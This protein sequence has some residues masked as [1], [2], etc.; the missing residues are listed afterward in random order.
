[1]KSKLF[2]LPLALLFVAVGC[3]DREAQ[4]NAKIQADLLSDTTI[5]VTTTKPLRQDVVQTLSVS[6]SLDTLD[7]VQVGAKV[8]GRLTLVSVKEGSR[9]RAG[10]LIAQVETTDLLLQVQQAQAA[11]QQALSRRAEAQIQVQMTPEQ[12]EAAVKQ[13]EAQLSAAKAQLELV[14]KGARSQ[15]KEQARQRVNQARAALDKARADL[16]RMRKLYEQEAISKADLDAVQAAHDQALAAYQQAVEAYDLIVEGARP[17]EIQQAE[18]AVR[19]AEEA[20]R[21]ARS[22]RSLTQ[23]R[24]QQLE[25]AEAAVTQA[26]AALRLAQAALADAAIYAPFD[27]YVSG[28]PAQV[29]QVVAPG[30]PVA[31]IVSLNGLYFDAQVS[32]TDV[33]QVRPGQPVT[34]RVDA[35]PSREFRGSVIAINPV[36]AELGRMFSVRVGLSDPEKVLRPGMFATGEIQLEVIP[37]SLV[38]PREAIL[39]EGEKAFV[40]IRK[41]ADGVEKIEVQAFEAQDSTVRVTGLTGEE[42]VILEGKEKLLP[43]SKIRVVSP[44]EETKE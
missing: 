18:Q 34:V 2:V 23:V 30:T 7:M 29:G 28:K 39:R 35:L 5:P 43:D 13:A 9:V 21:I 12:T 38:I 6:G 40:W 4:Q 37:N 32:E 3:A 17:E 19:Q 15:E 26:R 31:T 20:V 27:G 33:A 36:G 44:K 42:E 25:Q 11:L 1:M 24:R 41:G 22:N 10:Q 8:G 16:E 14:R